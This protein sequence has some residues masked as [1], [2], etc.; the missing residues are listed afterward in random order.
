[1]TNALFSGAEHMAGESTESF[2]VGVAG[3]HGRSNSVFMRLTWLASFIVLAIFAGMFI[4]LLIG[5][6]PA[7]HQFG[8]KFFVDDVW[9]PVTQK[10]GIWPLVY[11]TLV[12]SALSILMAA[13]IGI[14]VAIFLTS[15][16]PRILRRPLGITIELL[17]GIPSIIFGVWG[18]FV[19]VPFFQLNVQPFL[20]DTLGSIPVIGAVFAGPPFGIGIFTASI[21][22]AIMILPLVSSL[23]R[24]VFDIVPPVLKEAAYGLGCTTSEVSSK[25]VL[26]YARQGVV[27]AVMLALGR[28]LGETMAVTFVVGNIHNA[29]VSIFAPGTTISASIANEFS[30]AVEKLYSS[31]LL[32][33]G[34]F[35][36]FI[37][38]TVLTLAQLMLGGIARRAGAGN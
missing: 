13:P 8:F 31:A 3:R 22:L 20:V 33:A 19:F 9:N 11:G 23:V 17:A 2:K 30:E 16:C 35:L 36:M 6:Y 14:G 27:G 5:S 38:F 25:V 1:M 10:F 15:L 21:I 37:T 18:L 7:L 4:A 32:T 12:T 28:A 29:S 24:D 26:P 34:L